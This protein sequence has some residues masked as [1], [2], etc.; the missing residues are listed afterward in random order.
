MHCD[1]RAIVMLESK[2]FNLFSSLVKIT[3]KLD[4]ML[5]MSQFHYFWFFFY[6]SQDSIGVEWNFLLNAM[7]KEFWQS[8]NIWQ[9]SDQ[10]IWWVFF[11]SQCI[12]CYLLTDI[13]TE[14]IILTEVHCLPAQL[15][16]YH[17]QCRLQN[18]EQSRVWQRLNNSTATVPSISHD[19]TEWLEIA[20][21]NFSV[22][23]RQ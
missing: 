23:N 19:I 7:V 5:I 15:H 2:A 10:I 4:I 1:W 17:L 22:S 12:T 20:Y 3:K 8:A 9:S 18:T 6:I 16:V 13:Q 21:W 11:D 14:K